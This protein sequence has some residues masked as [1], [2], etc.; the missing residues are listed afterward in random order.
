MAY[1]DRHLQRTSFLGPVSGHYDVWTIPVHAIAASDNVDY[2]ITAPYDGR[3]MET[4]VH[5]DTVVSDPQYTINVNA[6]AV[7]AARN[8]PAT[9]VSE[10]LT[11]TST[12][13]LVE[14]ARTFTKGQ[15][16]LVNFTADAGDS[17]V[18]TLLTITVWVQSHVVAAE[19]ND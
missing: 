2:V 15:E 5:S 14:A 10:T 11:P 1:G 19:A 18:G 12:P 8:L 3:I 7:V 9:G 17:T 4:S 13:T 6:V 16:I